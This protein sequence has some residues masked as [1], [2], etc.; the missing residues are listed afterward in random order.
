MLGGSGNPFPANDNLLR[1]A[2]TSKSLFDKLLALDPTKSDEEGRLPLHAAVWN[3]AP[4]EVVGKLL[5]AHPAAAQQSA[6]GSTWLPLHIALQTKAPVSVVRQLIEAHPGGASTSAAYGWL[7]LHVAARRGASAEI[8][9]AVLA[10]NP[11]ALGALAESGDT[12][13]S[14]A[15][16]YGQHDAAKA[17]EAAE[18][19]ERERVAAEKR[20]SDRLSWVESDKK[21]KEELERIVEERVKEQELAR[22]LLQGSAPDK[23][24]LPNGVTAEAMMEAAKL[25]TKRMK[26]QFDE[27]AKLQLQLAEAAAEK[28]QLKKQLEEA[29]KPKPKPEAQGDPKDWTKHKA[30]NGKPFWYN[31]KTKK[32]VWNDPTG[33][34]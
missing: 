15:R 27:N 21:E 31:K 30:K 18:D 32:S 11:A 29:Q 4:T 33:G 24:K 23:T 20:E 7:P 9:E 28:E 17:L 16:K 5:A 22:K 2:R 25:Q 6:A 8:C 13:S 10:A 3:E 34:G 12:P 19:K 26:E 14:L 1:A